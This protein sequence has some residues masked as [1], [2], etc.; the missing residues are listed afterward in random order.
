IFPL[1]GAGW[2]GWLIGAAVLTV[3]TAGLLHSRLGRDLEEFSIDWFVRAWE[4]I[5]TDIV[6]G[7][8]WFIVH[9]F[10][11]IVEA[12]ER[13]LYSVDEWLR[14]KTGDSRLALALKA[15][16]GTAWSVVR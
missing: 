14:F 8:F 10:K 12:I 3:V 15:V 11:R 7:I 6:P 5:S 1:C 4:Q 13:A 9:F 2:N 16:F